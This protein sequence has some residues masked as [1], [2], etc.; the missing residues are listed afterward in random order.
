MVDAVVLIAFGGPTVR[1]EIRPFLANVTRGRRIS[2]ERLEEVAHHY[3]RMP[4]ARSPLNDL[5]LAQAKALADALARRGTPTDVRVGMRNWQP[6]L[7]EVLGELAGGG[8]RRC[9]G[10]IMSSLRCEASWDRYQQDVVEARAKTGGVPDV[11]FSPP[12]GRGR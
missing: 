3:E 1:D 7:H 2:A 5:T 10:I 6:Y 12:W 11:V 4:G 8:A 9:L